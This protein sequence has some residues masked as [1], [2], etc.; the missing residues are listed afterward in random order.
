MTMKIKRGTAATR[1]TLDVGQ[2]GLDTDTKEVWIGT[3][4]GNRYVGGKLHN[5]AGS[6]APTTNED[7]ADGYSVGSSWFDTTN[8][9]AYLCLDSTIG[10]A[11]WKDMTQSPGDLAGLGDLADVVITTPAN[12]QALKFDAATSTWTNQDDATG[13]SGGG[14]AFPNS[15]VNGGFD[16]A[17]LLRL[18]YPGTVTTSAGTAIAG[19]STDFVSQDINGWIKLSGSWYPVAGVSSTT[20]A[21][22]IGL[23]S[24]TG[25]AYELARSSADA[26]YAWDQWYSLV[27]T[28]AVGVQR[29]GGPTTALYAG[30]AIQL[31]GS[32]QRFGV[33][34]VV[35]GI[36]TVPLRGASTTFQASVRCSAGTAI[37]YALLAWT[38]TIDAPTKDVV[39]DW[40]SST[41]TAGNFFLASNVSVVGVGATTVSANTWTTIS[42]TG[43]MPTGA[44][45]AIVVIWTEGTQ[46]QGVTLDV[47]QADLF[48]GSTTRTWSPRDVACELEAC[49]RY[50]RVYG[51]LSSSEI[52]ATGMA[53][54]TTVYRYASDMG[55]W[56]RAL[57][58]TTVSAL[59]HFDIRLGATSVVPTDI[60]YSSQVYLRVLVAS[61][62]T[63]GT[64]YMLIANTLSA[65]MILDARM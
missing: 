18:A 12:G 25:V 55:R 13:G 43:T 52:I 29:V 16:I 58:S 61:G 40:A 37:R 53:D 44:N 54:S 57:P 64:S 41:Y 21:T 2:F 17:Q 26:A 48:P 62:L 32:A 39:N 20:A 7:S 47:S 28:A 33:A 11:V 3:D 51:G 59:T 22:S 50:L 46:A 1:P 8:D 15:L 9:K 5:F 63:A 45:N 23:P 6:T 65:R 56:M 35:E 4:G 19:T 30:R 10:A 24:L 60:L 14:S 36:H 38:G 27:Q 49:R 42:V 34:Q 31:Q